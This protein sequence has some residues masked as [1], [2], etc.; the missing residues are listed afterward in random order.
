MNSQY[1]QL[2]VGQLVR[3]YLHHWISLLGGILVGLAAALMISFFLITPQYQA[4]ITVYVNSTKN[5]QPIESIS[6]SNLTAAQQLVNT[7]VNIIKSKTVL[8]EVI[9]KAD[10]NC[11]VTD[12]RNIMTAKQ[13]DNTEMFS[14]SISHPNA[15]MAAHIANTIADVA[16]D[17][18][19]GFVKG[20]S[21][22]IIEYADIPTSPYKPNYRQNGILGGLVGCVL[23]GLVLTFRFIF[24]TRLK[25]EED[26][27]NYLNIPVLGSIPQYDGNRAH[28]GGRYENGSDRKGGN[29]L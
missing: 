3:H 25:K 18:I 28:K 12:I 8:K 21:T 14:V 15:E 4:S 2:N 6:G 19:S 10:L 22:E 17:R 5:S 7:Y 20:S 9:E 11:T 13:I 16:P 26:I 29:H 23:V 24:D 1:Y 27:T